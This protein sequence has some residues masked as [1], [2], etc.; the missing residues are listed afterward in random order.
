MPAGDFSKSS[1]GTQ[2]L[3]AIG[4]DYKLIDG[5]TNVD[6]NSDDVP[7]VK[8]ALLNGR[9][10]QHSGASSP[11]TLTAQRL[12]N[13]NTDVYDALV[14]AKH[15]G[16]ALQF[17]IFSG[18]EE[19]VGSAIQ[20][21][22]KVAIATTGIVTFTPA[23]TNTTLRD[24]A[25]LQIAVGHCIKTGGKLYRII[26][27]SDTDVVTVQDTA[28]RKA[29]SAAVTTADYTIVNPKWQNDGV[30]NIL[31]VGNFSVDGGGAAA[32][33]SFSIAFRNALPKWNVVI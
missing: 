20:T 1:I 27:I 9:S 5:L 12:A 16:T 30:A 32:T 11:E 26:G 14:D 29:P 28:T 22:D 8:Q 21:A 18:P 17:R 24:L 15:N 23:N 3:L 7:T 25:N 6:I 4:S 10:V 19:N 31:Q 2:V 33:D 13:Y